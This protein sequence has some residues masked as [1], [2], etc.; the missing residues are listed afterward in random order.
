MSKKKL[1]FSNRSTEAEDR[2]KNTLWTRSD[3]T[4]KFNFFPDNHRPSSSSGNPPV[5]QPTGSQA[6]FTGQASAFAFNFQI[7]PDDDVKM[8]SDAS[9]HL[10]SQRC[11]TDEKP[12]D[13]QQVSSTTASKTKKKK[14]SGKKNESKEPQSSTDQG[15][16]DTVLN[17]EEQLKRQLDW[18]IEQLEMGLRTQKGT[19][20]QKEETSRALKTLRSSKAPLAKKRQVMRVTMGDYRSKMEEEKSKQFKLIQSEVASA[21]VKSVPSS[22]MKSAFHRK[23][24]GK[25][26]PTV[27]EEKLAASPPEEMAAFVFTPSKEPFHFSFL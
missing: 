25:S 24:E 20:K 27:T 8:T 2:T 18:C 13:Q 23:T 16:E 17:A 14:K 15:G 1:L 6:D 4:F 19:P 10:N 12:L 26:Q 5:V 7:P 22:S 21:Q 9:S 11:D 3:N